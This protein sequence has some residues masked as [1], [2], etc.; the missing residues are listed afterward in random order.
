M[1][2]KKKTGRR[3]TNYPCLVRPSYPAIQLIGCLFSPLLYIWRGLIDTWRRSNTRAYCSYPSLSL[4][5]SHARLPY[6]NWK[7]LRTSETALPRFSRASLSTL[8]LATRRPT[9][10]TT[11]NAPSSSCPSSN[12]CSF[13]QISRTFVPSI[14]PCRERPS[15]RDRREGCERIREKKKREMKRT[16]SKKFTAYLV[17]S[18]NY[19][20]TDR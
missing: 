1:R 7:R 5:L 2:K 18:D 16:L 19:R 20:L 8:S 15:R 13:I 14:V 6:S 17:I 9:S 4:S 12:A 11:A 10:L 3:R